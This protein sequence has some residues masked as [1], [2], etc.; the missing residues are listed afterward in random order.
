V[1][2]PFED[3]E[4]AVAALERVAEDLEPDTFD[5]TQAKRAI[6][7][8]TRAELNRHS[9][10]QFPPWRR[11]KVSLSGQHATVVATGRDCSRGRERGQPAMRTDEAARP[12]A[13]LAHAYLL[14]GPSWCVPVW[15]RD[16]TSPSGAR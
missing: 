9:A 11:A 3:L 4:G 5:V 13:R 7:L 8:C 14:F 6:D 12:Q 15:Q 2:S 1:A 16:G 10:S